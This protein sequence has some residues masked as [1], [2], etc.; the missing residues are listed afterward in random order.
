MLGVRARLTF[1]LR[2]DSALFL[3]YRREL[4]HRGVF[5]MPENLGRSH[6]GAAHTEAD[7]DRALEAAEDALSAALGR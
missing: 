1:T 4:I 3:R 6:I 2:N 7:I 5:E